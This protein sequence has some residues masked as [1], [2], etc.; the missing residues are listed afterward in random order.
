MPKQHRPGRPRRFGAELHRLNLHRRVPAHP[1]AVRHARG[2][3]APTAR[4]CDHAPSSRKLSSKNRPPRVPRPA[5]GRASSSGATARPRCSGT[6]VL[7]TARSLRSEAGILVVC[8]GMYEE[9]AAFQRNFRSRFYTRSRTIIPPTVF[10]VVTI[11]VNE[12]RSL[13]TLEYNHINGSAQV[14]VGNEPRKP[15]SVYSMFEPADTES[16]ESGE[17]GAPPPCALRL[18]HPPSPP[19]TWVTVLFYPASYGSEVS[20]AQHSRSLLTG[21][22]TCTSRDTVRNSNHRASSPVGVSRRFDGYD[23][24]SHCTVTPGTNTWQAE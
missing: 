5:R 15:R 14:L 4:R 17:I 7:A 11:T 18:P 21:S 12:H 24:D 10:T 3:A 13:C 20:P 2:A 23:D 9:G 19:L 22:T 1:R 8:A 6:A 16:G